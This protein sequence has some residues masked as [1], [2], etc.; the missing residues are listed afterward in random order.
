MNP[1]GESNPPPSSALAA[2]L[3]ARLFFR[4]G[5]PRRRLLWLSVLLLLPLLAALAYRLSGEGEGSA[6]FRETAVPMFVEFFALGL[7]LYLGVASLADE[8]EDGTI[9][10]L[11]CRPVPRGLVLLAK[12]VAVIG[13]AGIGLS[14]S[15]LLVFLG[16]H[17]PDGDALWAA[18][19][20]LVR[21]LGVLWLE[22]LVYT[23]LFS[24]AGSLLRRPMLLSIIFGFGW[25]VTASHLPGDLPRLTLMFYLRSLLGLSPG[26]ENMLSSLV[27]P[28][29]PADAATALAVLLSAAG[30]FISLAAWIIGRREYRL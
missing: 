25:E 27:P 6:W 21:V 12:V 2:A 17:L 26:A 11:F 22:V 9:V 16:C 8:I 30:V 29:P 24:L 13:V 3:V 28:L 23:G 4:T 14:A 20:L 10:F 15:L 5:L 19:P 7:S 18:A 1:T